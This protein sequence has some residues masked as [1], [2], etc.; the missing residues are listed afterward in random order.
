MYPRAS[1]RKTLQQEYT[2]KRV[3][4]IDVACPYYLYMEESFVAK[5]ANYEAL[6]DAVDQYYEEANV[7]PVAVG[8]T[9]LVHRRTLQCLMDCGMLKNQA[10]GLCKWMSNSNIMAARDI[11]SIRCRLEKE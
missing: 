5:V 11:W 10:K 8:S 7:Y 6:R 2:N 9:G 1:G 3:V 4:I